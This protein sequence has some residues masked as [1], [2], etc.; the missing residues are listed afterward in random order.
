MMLPIDAEIEPHARRAASTRAPGT[1]I[2]PSV[3]L[4]SLHWLADQVSGLCPRPRLRTL[5]KDGPRTSRASGWPG[6]SAW[7]AAIS[8][9]NTRDSRHDNKA[10]LTDRLFPIGCQAPRSRV[11]SSASPLCP[12]SRASKPHQG[13]QCTASITDERLTLRT[14][15]ITRASASGNCK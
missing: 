14:R 7:R 10:P 15:A 4:T 6:A 3:D 8:T 12:I 9:V 1:V 2:L 13:L 5:A 11:G